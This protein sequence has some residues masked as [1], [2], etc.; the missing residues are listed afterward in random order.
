MTTSKEIDCSSSSDAQVVIKLVE[1][2]PDGRRAQA[3]FGTV[4]HRRRRREEREEEASGAR[5]NGLNSNQTKS[6]DQKQR[7][8]QNL[9][10]LH[11]ISHFSIVRRHQ[12]DQNQS[13]LIQRPKSNQTL[14]SNDPE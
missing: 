14:K 2:G 10:S 6:N 1:E 3:L 12:T 4:E 13:L 5:S 8:L 7:T 11:Q 9:Y